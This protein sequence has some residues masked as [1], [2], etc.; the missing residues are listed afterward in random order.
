ME[1]SPLFRKRALCKKRPCSWKIGG[2]LLDK[3]V[4]R[5]DG[6]GRLTDRNGACLRKMGP[7]LMKK[8]LLF[9][10]EMNPCLFIERVPYSCLIEIGAHA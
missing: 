7:C 9:L 8:S 2:G 6:K 3:I 5:L 1:K 4:A 10:L